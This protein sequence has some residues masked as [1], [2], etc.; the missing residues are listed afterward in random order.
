MVWILLISE[1]IHK[2]NYGYLAYPIGGPATSHT[3]KN[4]VAPEVLQGGNGRI[5]AK[6][7]VWML[8]CTVSA[9]YCFVNS[10]IQITGVRHIF[11]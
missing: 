11:Y 5:D 1:F 3:P 10:V 6:T 8:G 7:D 9:S 2:L 4:F